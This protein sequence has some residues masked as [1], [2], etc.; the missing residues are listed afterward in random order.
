MLLAGWGLRTVNLPATHVIVCGLV[1][2]KTVSCADERWG[3][4]WEEL[5][6][7]LS[8]RSRGREGQVD[9]LDVRTGMSAAGY[10]S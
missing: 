1:L 6:E 5:A 10:F 9:C 4:R 7:S 2:N 3:V 8:L